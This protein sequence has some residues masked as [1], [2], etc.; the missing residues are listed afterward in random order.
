MLLLTLLISLSSYLTS[1]SVL[2]HDE[3]DNITNTEIAPKGKLNVRGAKSSNLKVVVKYPSQLPKERLLMEIL[4]TDLANNQPITG[5]NI[6]AVFNLVLEKQ[7]PSEQIKPLFSNALATEA[8]GNYLAE[9]SFPKAGRYKL[10]LLMSKPGLNTQ[11]II[12]NIII[13]EKIP[14]EISV[15]QATSKSSITNYLW[16]I[17]LV[18]VIILISLW[19]IKQKMPSKTRH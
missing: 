1:L 12:P 10:T 3:A 11:V 4:L 19:V 18:I 7:D 8:A 13:A 15:N 17:V 6:T 5:V 14:I 2:A 16:G 9:V